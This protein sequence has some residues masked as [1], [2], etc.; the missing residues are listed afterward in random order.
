[1][2]IQPDTDPADRA[3]D[4]RLMRFAMEADAICTGISEVDW[5]AYPPELDR[6]AMRLH[7]QAIVL[8]M[9]LTEA[10]MPDE[11]AIPPPAARGTDPVSCDRDILNAVHTIIDSMKRQTRG[12][13]WEPGVSRLDSAVH[14]LQSWIDGDR[15]GTLAS[16]LLA[17]PV[18]AYDGFWDDLAVIL[19]IAEPVLSGPGSGS[20]AAWERVVAELERVCVNLARVEQEGE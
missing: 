5:N 7:Q 17:A 6:W 13:T 1:M 10:A 2:N 20:R 15:D 19:Y 4:E 16:P 18:R 12:I 3:M 9:G 11:D 8:A 14:H